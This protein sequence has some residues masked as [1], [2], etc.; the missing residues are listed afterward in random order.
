MTGKLALMRPVA[1]VRNLTH[2]VVERLSEEIRAGALKP[3]D[4]LPTEQEMMAA[5]GVSRTVVREAVSALRADGLVMTRQGVGAFVAADARRRPFRLDPAGMR[6]IGEVVNVMELRRAME[7][8][9]AGLAAERGTA[10]QIAAIGAAL[11]A[12]DAAIG[13]EGGAIEE[14]RA[15]H[16]AIAEATGN[17]QFTRFLDFLGHFAIPRRAVAATPWPPGGARAYLEMIQGEHRAIHAAIRDRAPETA[18]AAMRRHLTNSLKRYRRLAEAAA[19][20]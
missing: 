20:V 16:R 18:R 12:M 5:L 7:V 13:P 3:G 2:E 14:D 15:Y 8:D 19:G 17:P 10:A 1:P 9:A 4:K 11:D 6:S